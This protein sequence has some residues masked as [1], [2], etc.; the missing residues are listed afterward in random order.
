M[1]KVNNPFCIVV[2]IALTVTFLGVGGYYIA[3]KGQYERTTEYSGSYVDIS[4]QKAPIIV[5]TIFSIVI[6]LLY[7]FLI[8]LMPRGMI[9]TMIFTSLGLIG[10]L[11]I[12]GVVTQNYA[13]AITM[14][15]MLLIYSLVLFC[16][17]DRIKTGIVLVKVATN[18]ISDKPIVFL[19]PI[20]KVVLTVLFAVF[21]AYTL[22]LMLEKANW[23]DDHKEDSTPS[24]VFTGVWVLIWLFYTFFF[25]YIMVFTVA[26]TCAFWYYNVTDK[27]PIKTSYQWIYKSALGALTFAALLISIITF[28]RMIID[29]KR[30]DAKNLAV[31]VC[32]CILSCLLQQI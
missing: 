12:I 32:L 14:G 4:R 20:I 28:A 22:G 29:T 27:N 1:R 16:F 25:Y 2:L 8:K 30:K 31:A 21:W 5:C 19:T 15:I 9:L 6:S 24:R 11:C 26:V 13:L 23:Q 18:F 7:I 3:N 10:V 17:R